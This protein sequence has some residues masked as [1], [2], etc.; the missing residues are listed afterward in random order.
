MY[1]HLWNILRE[2]NFKDFCEVPYNEIEVRPRYIWLKES[3]IRL[4]KELKD[5]YAPWLII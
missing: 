3:L 4:D 1:E 5:H 2:I